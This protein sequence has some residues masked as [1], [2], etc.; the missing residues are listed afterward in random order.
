MRGAAAPAMRGAVRKMCVKSCPR[1]KRPSIFLVTAIVARSHILS[2]GSAQIFRGLREL[3]DPN[4]YMNSAEMMLPYAGQKV[5]SYIV[6]IDSA[7]F[8]SEL[9]A[10]H[11]PD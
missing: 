9:Q 6:S 2:I 5:D 4:Q 1:V 10:L 11:D 7:Q 8:F 3:P